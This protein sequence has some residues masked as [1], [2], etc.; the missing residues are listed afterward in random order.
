M[1]NNNTKIDQ[2]TLASILKEHH[3]WIKSDGKSGKRADLSEKDLKKCRF[4]G[5]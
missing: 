1:E 4:D 5:S 2:E 3:L